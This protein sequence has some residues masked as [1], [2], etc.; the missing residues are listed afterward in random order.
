M[1]PFQIIVALLSFIRQ[2]EGIR[3]RTVTQPGDDLDLFSRDRLDMTSLQNSISTILESRD[4]G[5]KILQATI[6]LLA[7]ASSRIPQNDLSEH[8]L[9]TMSAFTGLT[10]QF[11]DHV[12]VKSLHDARSRS[13]PLSSNQNADPFWPELAQQNNWMK[14]SNNENLSLHQLTGMNELDCQ[15]HFTGNVTELPHW[16]QS[17]KNVNSGV[18]VRHGTI[19]PTSEEELTTIIKNAMP[20]TLIPVGTGHSLGYALEPCK[21]DATFLSL[22][23]WKDV[24]IDRCKKTMRVGAGVTVGDVVPTLVDLGLALPTFIYLK[25]V[26]LVGLVLSQAQ[27]MGQSQHR[28][29]LASYVT[30]AV[31]MNGKGEKK[32]VQTSTELGGAWLGSMGDLGTVL[33]L[34]FALEPDSWSVEVCEVQHDL[35]TGL[36]KSGLGTHEDVDVMTT[37]FFDPAFPPLVLCKIVARSNDFE[38]IQSIPGMEHLNESHYDQ[39]AIDQEAFAIWQMKDRNFETWVVLDEVIAMMMKQM[40]WAEKNEI[41]TFLGLPVEPTKTVRWTSLELKKTWTGLTAE[42]HPIWS[43]FY[44]F[45]PADAI[46]SLEKLREIRTSLELGISI[47]QGHVVRAFADHKKLP[48]GRNESDATELF[49]ISMADPVKFEQFVEKFACAVVCELG[50]TNFAFHYA[51]LFPKALLSM[52]EIQFPDRD[53]V[54]LFKSIEAEEDP[55]DKFSTV[56]LQELDKRREETA[57]DRMCTYCA[58][59]LR[60]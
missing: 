24:K 37:Y 47:H 5:F 2:S 11:V 18:T 45:E 8:Q 54:A 42:N 40:S 10:A 29:S 27:G 38:T 58:P 48:I 59:H 13:N 46:I 31:V 23:N 53:R 17:G 51:E 12:L 56:F 7:L 6:S 9:S 57:S 26:T 49:M 3:L 16:I 20:G 22:W 19:F 30:E 32:T 15:I 34:E 50:I 44:F 52:T 60:A 39:E 33:E 25:E 4:R 21:S 43:G 36:G 14:S 28:T 55:I 1:V 41:W 35:A